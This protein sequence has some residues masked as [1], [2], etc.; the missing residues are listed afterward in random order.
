M[1]QLQN[2]FCLAQGNAKR[3]ILLWRSSREDRSLI[4]D[5]KFLL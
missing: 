4:D 2:N 3:N 5:D 1:Y